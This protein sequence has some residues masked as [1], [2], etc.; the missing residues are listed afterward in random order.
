MNQSS[1]EPGVSAG[2]ASAAAAISRAHNR[3]E[4]LATLQAQLHP[5]V[6][7]R[8]MQLIWRA[9]GSP[10]ALFAN[11][12]TL[13]APAAGERLQLSAGQIVET[14]NMTYLPILVLGELRGWLAVESLHIDPAMLELVT[15]AGTA[16]ELMERRSS[17]TN[18]SREL[19]MMDKIGSMLSSTLQLDQLLPNLADVVRDLVIADDFYIIL[20]DEKTNKLSFSYFSSTIADALP[21]RRWSR[22]V[23]LTGLIMRTG[24]PIVTDDYIQECKRHGIEPQIPTGIP[25]SHAWVGMPLRHHDQVLGVMVASSHDPHFRYTEGDVHLM[26]SVA[27]QAAAAVANAQLY[28]RVKQQATQLEVINRIGRTISATLDPQEIPMLI[29]HELKMALDVEDGS[30]LIEDPKTGDLVVRYT[31]EPHMGLRIPKGAGLASEALR[32]HKVRIANDVQHDPQLYLPVALQGATP[33]QSLICA[34]LEGRQQLRGVIQLRNKQHGKFTDEDAQLLSAVA[35]QAAVALENAE[36]YSDTDSALAAHIADLEQRNRQLNR[37][38]TLSDRLRSASDLHEVGQQIVS[39]IQAMTGS[40][41]VALGLVERE[42]QH[43]RGIARVTLDGTAVRSRRDEGD[44]W[45]PLLVAEEALRRA[46]KIG[47]IT[48]HV[49]TYERAP[50]FKDCIALTLLDSNGTLVGVIALDHPEHQAEPF[51]RAMIQELEIVANQA[52][53]AVIN[54]RLADEQEQT[55]DRLTAL[56]ALSL[57]VTTSRLSTDEVM[58]MTVRGAIGTTNGVGGGAYVLGR[59]DQP[60][61]LLLNLPDNCDREIVPKLKRIADEYLEF[62]GEDI[63]AELRELGIRSLLIT[64]VSGAQSTLGGLWIGYNYPVIAAAEREMVVLYAKMAGAVLEN[65]RLFDQVSSAHDRLASILASTAEGMLMATK[66]GRI[67]AANDALT[68]LLGIPNEALEGRMISDLCHHP[69]LAAEHEHLAEICNAIKCVARKNC[70]EHEGEFILSAP[71][72]RNLAW[73]V[74][75]IRGTAKKHSAALLVLR[76]VTAERQTEKLRQDLANMIVHDLRSPLTNMMV[77][78]DLL[79]KQISGPLNSAQER[80]IQI[81]SDSSQQMLDLVNALLDIRRLEQRQLEMQTQPAE[82]YELVEGVFTRIERV[83]GE[84]HIQLDNRTIML[85]PI[86]VDVDLIRR[87]LQNLIDNS[88]KFS[89]QGGQ[90]QVN[91]SVAA[92]DDLPLGHPEGRWAIVEVADQGPGVPESY[93][94]VIF[95]LFGQAPQ[96]KG[97]GTGLGLA[98]CKLVIVAHGGT[99][100]VEDRPG[101]GALF[102]FTLPVV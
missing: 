16:L 69:A 97:R 78:T 25:F 42:R 56:N 91:A 47:S 79:L 57:A 20:E 99:I 4:L 6:H 39:T 31:L 49:G 98:F 22:S 11:Q 33:T 68:Y 75:P 51:S 54:A 45:T 53:V 50:D 26:S 92:P 55:V 40:P 28:R 60:R 86:C 85:P 10:R 72:M 77:S 82:L 102:R 100:W 19:A 14:K 2:L 59:D 46:E 94:S 88:T 35:E 62:T 23:G 67:A 7:A 44:H 43:M 38:V 30:V 64:P 9:K 89:P 17:Q 63:P 36:L 5:F 52:A 84:R 80:I 95:E 61:H 48:Y 32:R 73:T 76:D 24:E 101:G 27:A 83:A 65:R 74:M 15:Y 13:P 66:Q 81:A 34:P 87:V 3:S 93:R 58:Q 1:S 8:A 18:V 41:R 29:M 21:D 70:S 71:V 37:I 96:G 12:P 90:I